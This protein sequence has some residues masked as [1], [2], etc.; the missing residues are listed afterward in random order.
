MSSA[1]EAAL[2]VGFGSGGRHGA[3]RPRGMR[4][5]VVPDRMAVRYLAAHEGGMGLCVAADEKEAGLDAFFRERVEDARRRRIGRAVVEGE[6]DF[7]I[8]ERQ[9]ARIGFQAEGDGRAADR[10]RAAGPQGVRRAGRGAGRCDGKQHG[11]DKKRNGRC[12]SRNGWFAFAEGAP[13]EP[14]ARPERATILPDD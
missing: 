3:Q 12:R 9:R 11:G 13:Y 2:D 6:D 4:I 5:G 7:V 1:A 14:E 10:E 8:G